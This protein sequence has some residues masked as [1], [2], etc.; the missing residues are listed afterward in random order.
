SASVVPT[1]LARSELTTSPRTRRAKLVVIPHDGHGRWNIRWKLHGGSP[2]VW[3][4]AMRRSGPSSAYGRT[5]V[6]VKNTRPGRAAVRAR[7]GGG[8]GARGPRGGGAGDRGGRRPYSVRGGPRCNRL[9]ESNQGHLYECGTS[10]FR[11]RSG[12][13]WPGWR[14]RGPG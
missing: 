14:A 9:S 7:P 12:P 11:R 1:Q 3:C 5:W 2:S 6:A 8:R 13:P 4:E 10:R